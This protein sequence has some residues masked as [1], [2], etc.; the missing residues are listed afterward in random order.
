MFHTLPLSFLEVLGTSIYLLPSL[1]SLSLTALE[2]CRQRTRV[3]CHFNK[4][5]NK[6]HYLLA[7]L[8]ALSKLWLLVSSWKLLWLGWMFEMWFK[9]FCPLILT[10][11]AVSWL[12][13]SPG[14][15]IWIQNIDIWSR[16]F[17]VLFIFV[18]LSSHIQT[19]TDTVVE[20]TLH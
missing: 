2:L 1:P 17:K 13:R 18:T 10:E 16:H 11:G 3:Q 8:Y 20:T 19:I 15:K 12:Q 9:W 7:Y 5:F 14:R 4:T 6:Y